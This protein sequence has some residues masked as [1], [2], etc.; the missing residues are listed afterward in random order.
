MLVNVSMVRGS[1]DNPVYLVFQF[2]DIT[3]R[4]TEEERLV[5]SVFHDALT[6]LPNRALLMDRLQTGYRAS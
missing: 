4:K 6:G 2:Q 5:H 3:S 1:K